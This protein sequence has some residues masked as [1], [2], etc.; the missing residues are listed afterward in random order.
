MG[1]RDAFRERHPHV[2]AYTYIRPTGCALRLD[3]L[4]LLRPPGGDYEVFNSAIV[5]Q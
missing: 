2:R 1:A 3:E 5:M 4:W